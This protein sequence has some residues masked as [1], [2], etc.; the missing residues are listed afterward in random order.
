MSSATTKRKRLA[1]DII[2]QLEDELQDDN[3][4]MTI[5][6]KLIEEV[7]KK[8][9]AE[10]VRNV[11]ERFLSL[12]PNAG[13][14]WTSYI[15]YELERAE[16]QQEFQRIE[17]LFARCLTKVYHVD[18]WKCYLVY[19]RRVHNMITGGESARGVVLK[20]FSFAVDNVGIDFFSD[21]LWDE[22]LVFIDSWNP[23]SSAETFAKTDLKRSVFRRII[24]TP[25]NNLEKYWQM[26]TAFEN[27]TNPST[28][29][30]F[31]NEK[32]A[33]YMKVRSVVQ[34]LAN[35]T[36]GLNRNLLM[37]K[38]PLPS[39]FKQLAVWKR[40]IAWE[41][42]NPLKLPD[43]PHRKRVE[44]SF[45]Q[46]SQVVRF[47]PEIW[48]N[49]VQFL[50]TVS[51]QLNFEVITEISEMGLTSNP[52][53]FAL[54]YQIAELYEK[55][56][57]H[58]S[59]KR[60][61]ER[62]IEHLTKK[63]NYWSELESQLNATLEENKKEEDV[64][65]VSKD[66]DDTETKEKVVDSAKLVENEEIKKRLG[67]IQ[68]TKKNLGRAITAV[69]CSHM[70]S[71]KRCIGGK[72]SRTIFAEAR[73]FAG[74]T[75][76]IYDDSAMIEY[77]SNDLKLALRTFKLAFKYFGTEVEFLI[78]YIDF[79]IL[80]KDLANAKSVFE[81]SVKNL[82][83]QEGPLRLLFK[84][85]MKVELNYGDLSSVKLLEKRYQESFPNDDMLQV[86]Q[87]RYEEAGFDGIREFDLH[88]GFKN[89][90]SQSQPL[91]EE[92]PLKKQNAVANNTDHFEDANIR[93]SSPGLPIRDPFVV[94]DEI[95][96]LLRVLPKPRYYT[97]AIFDAEKTVKFFENL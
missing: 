12:F 52:D 46:A 20:A 97:E 38:E 51:E 5:W 27:E 77:Y 86:F 45:K 67:E 8:D 94:R 35:V 2:G 69:Y 91:A 72:E 80:N 11:Y 57:K 48:F 3:L 83:T 95:Y 87:S 1:Q 16:S 47:F 75:W 14:Q 32:S 7:S 13:A 81:T 34:E 61:Y 31:I 26:Y 53:S 58:D 56:M 70:K 15:N 21:N 29:R 43:D 17:G 37:T 33:E 64:E 73:K 9:K 24:G 49:Y 96:N 88:H 10:D 39:D 71:T 60:C 6:M 59:M 25:L 28:S 82:A 62:L 54:T 40:W 23:I 85:F 22:Y 78:R 36:S 30:K 44:Y 41:L 89:E 79:L 84:K 68:L 4:N 63:Y 19:V 76:H 42:S 50:I 92:P 90:E 65:E 55:N 66:D 18:L 93:E 74:V